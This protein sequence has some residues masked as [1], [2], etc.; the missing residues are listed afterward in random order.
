MDTS[1]I[2]CELSTA[3]PP[4]GMFPLNPR[5]CCRTVA[6]AYWRVTCFS[7]ALLVNHYPRPPLG[8]AGL[9]RRATAYGYKQDR[10]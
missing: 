5:P 1:G 8:A 3:S 4:L 10:A 6:F 9:I 7:F 2:V